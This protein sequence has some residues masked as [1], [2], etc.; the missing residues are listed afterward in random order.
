MSVHSNE[1][2][3]IQ[4]E[5]MQIPDTALSLLL[6]VNVDERIHSAR[7][8]SLSTPGRPFAF[9]TGLAGRMGRTG[10]RPTRVEPLIDARARAS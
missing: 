4:E 7:R 3:F 5:A 6:D 1:R 10:R 8:L 9:L 2:R